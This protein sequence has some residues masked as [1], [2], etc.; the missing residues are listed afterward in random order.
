MSE[1]KQLTL[2]PQLGLFDAVVT[3]LAAILGAGILSVIASAS[4]IA[5]P[6]LLVSF[7]IAAFVAFCNALSSS[8]ILPRKTVSC[9]SGDPRGLGV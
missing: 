5:G 2:K 3:G 9:C 1:K 4:G 6:A 7:G 8:T